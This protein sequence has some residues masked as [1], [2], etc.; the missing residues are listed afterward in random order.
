MHVT[1]LTSKRCATITYCHTLVRPAF[2]PFCLGDRGEPA[3]RRWESWTRETKLWAH[4]RTHLD[5]SR[6]PLRCPHPLCSLQVADETLL[7]Y[8]LTDVHG[9]QMSPQM[10][11][12]WQQGRSSGPSIN[13]TS[14]TASQKRKSP[15]DNGE[16][17]RLSKRSKGLPKVDWSD[18]PST[19]HSLEEETYKTPEAMPPHMMSE[20]SFI[21][22]S[23]ADSLQDLPD[24]THSGPS[25]TPDSDNFYLI[26]DSAPGE[27]IHRKEV[28]D[29]AERSIHS[30][31]YQDLVATEDALFSQYLCSRSPSYFP[32]EEFG[33]NSDG[34]A[35]STT[36]NLSRICLFAEEDPHRVG[37][38][39]Q[40]TIESTDVPVKAKKPRIKLRLR[41][42]EPRPKPKVLLRLSQPKQALPPK[43]VLRIKPDVKNRRRRRNGP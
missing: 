18:D 32:T 35:H 26:D 5:V 40:N 24:L 36:V 42:P 21:D 20:V 11:K 33:D 19:C 7:L 41:Q 8:H 28:S 43:S 1:S 31:E 3:C 37:L 23:A 29:E 22:I 10:R 6:W 15:V 14:T 4:L 17:S 2:C 12:C 38:I 16:T 27:T 13:W 39:D 25:S 30:G 34:S 9:L